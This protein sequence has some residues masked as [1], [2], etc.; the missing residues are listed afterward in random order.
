MS[1][2]DNTTFLLCPGTAA[3]SD[4]VHAVLRARWPESRVVT[5]TDVASLMRSVSE[6]QPSILLVSSAP[7]WIA[8][9][10]LWPALRAHWHDIPAIVLEDAALAS[11]AIPC[12]ADLTAI[13]ASSI[14]GYAALAD[15]VAEILRLHDASDSS[16]VS[17]ERADVIADPTAFDDL[18]EI[19]Y[20]VSHDLKAPLQQCARLAKL[21]ASD[22]TDPSRTAV[23]ADQLGASAERASTILKGLTD[24][25]R[26]CRN[27][28]SPEPVDL[29]R[30]LQEAC[31][32][33][34]EDIKRTKAKITSSELPQVQAHAAPLRHVFQNLIANALKFSEQKPKIKIS[35]SKANGRCQIGVADKGIGMR[36]EALEQIFTLGT[37]LDQNYP[38]SGTGLA[39]CRR[40][41]ERYGGEIWAES[42]LGTGSTFFIDLPSAEIKP[43]INLLAA[44]NGV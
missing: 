7:D 18:D 6:C 40:I 20:V 12:I 39:L 5:V 34:R 38:G 22:S 41:V 19:E 13:V 32:F 36:P 21:V 1:E 44:S 28:A 35:A 43:T 11:S 27:T 25:I 23:L 33:L 17:G 2:P 31:S 26:A 30:C 42:E 16:G 3:S 14:E 4:L 9:G 15:T 29:S 24:Y 10:D 37:R 8:F